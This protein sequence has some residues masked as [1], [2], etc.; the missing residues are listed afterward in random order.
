MASR[1]PSWL[2]SW[3]SLPWLLSWDSFRYYG[4]WATWL[5]DAEFN[6]F[7]YAV[8]VGP[9]RSALYATLAEVTRLIGMI[10]TMT[11]TMTMT[12]EWPTLIVDVEAIT[13]WDYEASD[14]EANSGWDGEADSGW[15]SEAASVWDDPD[16]L[17]P[18]D[19][20]HCST[21]MATDFLWRHDEWLCSVCKVSPSLVPNT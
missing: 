8:M 2:F 17:C 12:M 1:L 10:G 16:R 5:I 14:D 13:S 20:H 7:M 18:S 11:P 15:D 9:V 4:D 19:S 21:C 3:D 6:W